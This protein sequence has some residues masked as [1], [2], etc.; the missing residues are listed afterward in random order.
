[1]G[2]RQLLWRGA[3]GGES[4]MGKSEGERK[5]ALCDQ[6]RGTGSPAWAPS[7]PSWYPDWDP[8]VAS[9]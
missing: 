8:E 2:V 7:L 3:C 9:E 4:G 1:M 6:G 5:G